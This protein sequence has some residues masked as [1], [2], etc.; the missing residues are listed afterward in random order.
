MKLY[1]DSMVVRDFESKAPP[2]S[3]ALAAAP[4]RC[5]GSAGI[6]FALLSPFLLILLTGVIELGFAGY[7][8]MQVQAAVEAGALY[9]AKHGVS[10]PAN[11]MTA[12][13]SATGTPGITA[14]TQLFCGCP[15]AAGV[16]KQADCT[17]PCTADNTAPGHYVTVSASLPHTV[18]MPFLSLPLPTML[19]ASS[20]IRVQ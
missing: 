18:L 16:L 6:E 5:R 7:Q 14:S 12:V 9:A 20:T 17:T 15:T 10:S 11:I 4:R 19:T 13:G 3:S 1:N 8:A 2:R